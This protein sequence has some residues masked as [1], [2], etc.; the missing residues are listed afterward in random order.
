MN[1]MKRVAANDRVAIHQEGVKHHQ[2]GDF[3]S[4]FEYYTK[5][6]ELGDAEAHYLLSLLYGKG[7]VVEKGERKGLYHLEEGPLPVILRLGI[8][9]HAMRRE[10]VGL[11]E[12]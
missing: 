7:Q 12:L 4:A 6:A 5:A 8:F 9:S 10:R 2:S 3:A 11:I 1:I